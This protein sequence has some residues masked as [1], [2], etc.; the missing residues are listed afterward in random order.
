M[1][2]YESDKSSRCLRLALGCVGASALFSGLRLVSCIRHGELVSFV[3]V[4]ALG[5]CVSLGFCFALCGS[6]MPVATPPRVRRIQRGDRWPYSSH[7]VA[8]AFTLGVVIPTTCAASHDREIEAY[9]WASIYEAELVAVVRGE[10][11]NA[12]LDLGCR[13]VERDG[14]YV[15]LQIGNGL[16]DNWAAV[17]YDPSDSILS[18]APAAREHLFGGRLVNCSRLFAGWYYCNFT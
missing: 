12:G 2:A 13:S 10:S 4:V 17:V 7:G 6:I 3:L 16:L 15:A 1:R 8:L 11:P 18:I 14:Q 5:L 9:V